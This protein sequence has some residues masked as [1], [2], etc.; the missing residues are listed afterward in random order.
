MSPCPEF[1]RNTRNT[2][3]APPPPPSVSRG[4]SVRGFRR[5]EPEWR[6]KQEERCILPPLSLSHARTHTH[7]STDTFGLL[8]ALSL[9]PLSP[10]PHG[11]AHRAPEDFW[12]SLHSSIRVDVNNAAARTPTAEVSPSHNS[13]GADET[14]R[15]T[16]IPLCVCVWNA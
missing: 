3:C 4:R 12:I 5:A 9:F 16:L 10:S 14:L 2:P 6:V 13:P 1:I 15:E 11:H 7:T 8:R